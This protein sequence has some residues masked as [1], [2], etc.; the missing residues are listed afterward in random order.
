[1]NLVTSKQIGLLISL[2]LLNSTI[3]YAHNHVF[4]HHKLHAYKSISKNE[5]TKE[6][7]DMQKNMDMSKHENMHDMQG[8]SGMHRMHGMYGSYDMTREASGTSWQPQSTPFKG[9]MIM[10]G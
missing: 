5:N 7:S 4:I 8:M 1:M 3:T 6:M 2:V 9:A 10:S